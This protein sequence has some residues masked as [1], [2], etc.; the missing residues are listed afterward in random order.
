MLIAKRHIIISIKYNIKEGGFRYII[1][2][3][4][5]FHKNKSF[6]EV[7]EILNLKEKFVFITEMVF[8]NTVPLAVDF[9]TIMAYILHII[10]RYIGLIVIAIVIIYI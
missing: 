1:K 5:D 2:L 4:I 7:L 6:R 9:I 8:F 10:N 3:L